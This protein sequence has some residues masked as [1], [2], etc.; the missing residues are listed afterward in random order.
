M[1]RINLPAVIIL[2]AFGAFIY[3]NN[4]DLLAKLPHASRP[5]LLAHRGLAQTFSHDGLSGDTCTATRI[6]PPEHPFLEN[7]LEL[8]AGC[9]RCRSRC[10]R[11][12]RAS[13][14]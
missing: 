5:T 8:D 12:R 14:N 9:L 4:T 13:H 7:T 10:R 2:L 1:R 11:V 6:L 3:L